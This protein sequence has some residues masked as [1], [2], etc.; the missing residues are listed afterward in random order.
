VSVSENIANGRHEVAKTYELSPY[1]KPSDIPRDSFERDG[2]TYEI[3][4]ITQKEN[5]KTEQKEQVE[6]VKLDSATKD[7]DEILKLLPKSKEYKNGGFTGILTLDVGSITIGQA[8][9]K[10][11]AY[12]ISE[13]REYP[14]LSINDS[15][16]V[17]KSIVDKYGRTLTLSN[18]TWRSQSN[19]AVDYNS[20]PD[21]YTACATYSGTAYKSVVTGYEVTAQY[22][23]IIG[24]TVTGKTVYTALFIGTEIVPPTVEIISKTEITTE[25]PTVSE[26]V[27]ET[28]TEIETTTILE[29]TTEAPTEVET[30]TEIPTVSEE[31]ETTTAVE[32][33]EETKSEATPLNPIL[34]IIII[35]ETLGFIGVLY[36]FIKKIQGGHKQDEKSN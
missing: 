12:T 5:V 32:I 25:I 4:D 9:T 24:K 3:S 10:S 15:S 22:R 21:S 31:I 2:C 13:T 27:I 26:S 28:T 18:L 29:I 16:L 11:V 14:Y 1:D 20:V 33:T 23:G 19:V 30:T 7:F 36:Y 8:G 17:P 35:A 6:T 34:I